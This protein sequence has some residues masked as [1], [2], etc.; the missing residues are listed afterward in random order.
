MKEHLNH[1]YE[2]FKEFTKTMSGEFNNQE[3]Q[4][5]PNMYGDLKFDFG[6][7]SIAFEKVGNQYVEKSETLDVNDEE[8]FKM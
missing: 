7:G 8:F 3:F 6:E 2:N 1:V 4:N 5:K